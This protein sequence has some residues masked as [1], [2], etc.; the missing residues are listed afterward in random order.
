EPCQLGSDRWAA[1]IAAWDKYHESCLVINIGTAMTVDALSNDGVFLGGIIVPSSHSLLNCIQKNTQIN[2]NHEKKFCYK[3]FP[4]NTTNAIFS[5]IVQSQIGSIERMTRL[6]HLQQGYAV[7]NCIFSGGGAADILP[8][9]NLKYTV[10]ENLV[11][12]GLL[13][14]AK[15][16]QLKTNI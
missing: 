13:I 7:K 9:V 8:Y 5:G 16:M 6:F 1:L 2:I 12:D 15:E 3:A 4:L 14:I 10:I 11:L